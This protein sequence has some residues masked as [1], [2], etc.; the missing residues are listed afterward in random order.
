MT[1]IPFLLEELEEL[2]SGSS[3]LEENRFI[4]DANQLLIQ[5]KLCMRTEYKKNSPEKNAIE[6]KIKKYE[7]LLRE[8]RHKKNLPRREEKHKEGNIQKLKEAQ[9]QLSETE[10][11]AD[12]ILL[13]LDLQKKKIESSQQKVTQIRTEELPK[14]NRF[15]TSMLKWWK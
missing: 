11:V 6:E 2:F 15:V 8:K 5:L 1:M 13:N 10:K 9:L 3:D 4:F 12:D 14:S 7:N